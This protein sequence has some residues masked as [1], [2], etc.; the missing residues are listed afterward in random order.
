MPLVATLLAVG[1]A[2]LL[3]SGAGP[4]AAQNC[5]CPDDLCCSQWGYCGT[6]D[7]YCGDGC[8]SGPC[9]V[10]SGGAAAAARKMSGDKAVGSKRTP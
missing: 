6:G 7:A 10:M 2:V 5:G 8:Q 4:A 3:L 1:L 9:T